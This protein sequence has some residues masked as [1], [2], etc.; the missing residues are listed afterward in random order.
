MSLAPS[1][2]GSSST[3][4]CM[5]SRTSTA[6]GRTWSS[7]RMCAWSCGASRTWRSSRP[8]TSPIPR[9]RSSTRRSPRC[10][11]ATSKSTPR[12]RRR[13]PRRPRSPC[14]TAPAS[15]PADPAGNLAM[16]RHNVDLLAYHDLDGR[17]GLKLALQEAG[18]RFFLYVAGFWHSGWSILEVTD[19]EHPQL[20]RSWVSGGTGTHRN[21][22]NGGPWVYATSNLPGFEGQILAIID[23]ADPAN[24]KMAGTWWHPGQHQAGGEAYTPEDQRKLT[25]GRPYPQH[26]LSLHGG[27]YALGDRAYCPWMRAGMVILD[28]TDKHHPTHIATLP[29]YPPLGSTIAVH[30]AVPLPGRDIVVINSEALREDCDEPAGYAA[31]V[32]VSDETDPILMAVF[33]PPRP[34]AGYDAP[35]FCAKGGR[36]GPHNQHQQQGLDC[37]APNDRYVYVAYFNAGLQIYDITDPHDPHITG[38]YIPDDPQQRRGPIPAKLVHQAQDVLVDRRA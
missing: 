17:S 19:P 25:A 6:T 11:P 5:W 38:Y 27:A 30:S 31:T 3:A 34:P 12:S 1:S 4:R 20:L 22:Y 16:W 14:P 21:F 2:A 18:G 10:R 28:I 13:S 15:Q 26:G 35:G 36:A 37:L 24:P 8:S 7:R 32:D 23:I 33:P 29:V 9:I